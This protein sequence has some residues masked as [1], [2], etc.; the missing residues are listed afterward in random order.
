MVGNYKRLAN[1]KKWNKKGAL[2]G[3]PLYMIILVAITAMAI[4][5]MF[6]WINSLPKPLKSVDITPVSIEAGVSTDISLKAWTTANKPMGDVTITF[7]GCGITESVV[8]SIDDN[9][10]GEATVTLNPTLPMNTDFGAIEVTATDIK[11]NT[12][13]YSISV[14]A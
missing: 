13:T 12:V 10:K 5:I 9:N 11:G 4:V 8:T 14:H 6:G 7:S 2:E 3:L 1:R